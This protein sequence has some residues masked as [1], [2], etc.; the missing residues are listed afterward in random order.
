MMNRKKL[1]LTISALFVFFAVL[2][3]FYALFFTPINSEDNIQVNWISSFFTETTESIQKDESSSEIPELTTPNFPL[4]IDQRGPI[5]LNLYGEV[6]LS[7]KNTPGILIPAV[8]GAQVQVIFNGQLILD[9]LFPRD[10]EKS[11]Q[12]LYSHIE[13][14][15]PDFIE[16]TNKVIIQYKGRDKLEI[17]TSPFFG[18]FI[19]LRSQVNTI[20]FLGQDFYLI[21]FGMGAL[22]SVILISLG[23]HV[24]TKKNSY[25]AM[26]IAMI[27][28]ALGSF[29][30]IV[31]TPDFFIGINSEQIFK[32]LQPISYTLFIYFLVIGIE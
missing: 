23:K 20:R 24:A 32:V 22:L 30:Y 4:E 21:I 31:N 14:I 25:V 6:E 19:K 7:D 9:T 28:N 11:S 15:N 16:D 26:G 1:Y 5:Y 18:D 13:Q 8:R 3:F 10:F 17:F 27:F 2:I 29:L 12:L